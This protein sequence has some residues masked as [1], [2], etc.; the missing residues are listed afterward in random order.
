MKYSIYSL[1]L[2]L[3]LFSTLS[4][5]R[6]FPYWDVVSVI[7]NDS[8]SY[9]AFIHED[10]QLKELNLVLLYKKFY[11]EEKDKFKILHRTK[12]GREF[13]RAVF[14]MSISPNKRKVAFGLF[15]TTKDDKRVV[16]LYIHDFVTKDIHFVNSYQPEIFG[17][18]QYINK[19]IAGWN[20][21]S[22]EVIFTPPNL[23]NET[24]AS[25]YDLEKKTLTM[26]RADN[27]KKLIGTHKHT[28]RSNNYRLSKNKN[29]VI[30]NNE[31]EI[32]AYYQRDPQRYT[33]IVY[34]KQD[35][36][37]F[38]SKSKILSTCK[39]T[40]FEMAIMQE[41]AGNLKEALEWHKKS[42]SAGNTTSSYIFQPNYR[43]LRKHARGLTLMWHYDQ[44]VNHHST[45]SMFEVTKHF[46]DIG[47][48][49]KAEHYQSKYDNLTNNATSNLARLRS[50]SP[51]QLVQI[52][53][54][55]M[56]ALK[57]QLFMAEM[58]SNFIN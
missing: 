5:A 32:T 20:N 21:S 39:D 29:L 46:R 49:E 11:N 37:K 17:S 24:P 56:A 48:I 1:S 58:K 16:A 53:S 51:R 3:M 47:D 57:W 30:I 10:G 19:Q 26:I 43:T 40:C 22:T 2:F 18:E 33:S 34:I 9:T 31:G 50:D 42:R 52:S 8:Y 27:H 44:A 4:T 23:S 6:D 38:S 55:E 41:D 54:F 12:R 13:T 35:L 14:P 45:T 15:R 25:L 28:Y 36:T 7:Q